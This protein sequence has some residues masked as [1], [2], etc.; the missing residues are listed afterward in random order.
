M[1]SNDFLTIRQLAEHLRSPEERLETVIRRLRQY[2]RSGRLPYHQLVKGGVLR[3]R[4]S[5][6]CAALQQ[7]VVERP[8][9]P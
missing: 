6:V 4:L 9:T 5:E 7:S 3:F 2:Q 8:P 1:L